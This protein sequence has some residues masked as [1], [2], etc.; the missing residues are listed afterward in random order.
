DDGSTDK[1]AKLGETFAK[2]HKGFRVLKEPHRGKGGTVIAGVLAAQGEI[3]LFTDMDQAT[4]MN[5]FEKFI[6]KFEENYD[7]VIGSRSG[8]EGAPLF[9][10]IMAYGFAFLRTLILR[11]PYKDTQCGFKAFKKDAARKIFKRMKIFNEKAKAE[12][13]TAG[14]DLELLYIARKLKLKV[15]EIPVIWHHKSTERISAVKDSWQGFRDMMRVRINALS[16]K[17]KV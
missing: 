7:I 15:A 13:V 8:R 16:G 4:P 17:Y 2:K 14:F 1:T 12:G 11:L 5:Q 3:I 10:K 9:R 6:P